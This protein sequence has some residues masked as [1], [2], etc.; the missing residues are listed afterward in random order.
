MTL[1]SI[2]LVNY[3]GKKI[4]Q[5]C[6]Q[7]LRQFNH[8]ILS[9]IIVVDNASEDGSP[10][11]ICEHFPEVK[12]IRESV[13][14]GF[15]KG[16]NIGAK[17][18]QGEYILFLNTDT[19]LTCDFLPQLLAVMDKNPQ[20]GIVAPKLLNQDG[21][22]QISTSPALG[23]WGEFLAQRRSS[24]Y[25]QGKN[26]QYIERKFSQQ[27]E[28]DLV[29][30]AALLI[31]QKLFEQLRGF[32]ENFF[33]Y[34]EEADLCQRAQY[35]GWKIIYEPGVSL[36]HLHGASTKKLPQQMLLEYRRSQVYYYQKH[37]PL[38]EQKFLQVYLVIKFSYLWLT[39][40]LPNQQL[41]KNTAHQVILTVWSS[42]PDRFPKG[43]ATPTLSDS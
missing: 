36:I 22:L 10:E 33:M 27:Q 28:V 6:L 34:F 30:G 21:S 43:E 16:N 5:D 4:I 8:T 1:V 41:D 24:R 40:G 17:I 31:R 15:G 11:L 2:I 32:D 42:T 39:A 29:V 38:W 3:N 23:V 13:N 20:V 18:A 9:E 37:R 14:H 19:I 12:L 7:S 25:H 35:L 26:K